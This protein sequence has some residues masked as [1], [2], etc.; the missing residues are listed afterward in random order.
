MKKIWM[1]L[2][3]LLL[4]MIFCVWQSAGKFNQPIA[5]TI[6]QNGKN[7]T[8]KGKFKDITQPERLTKAFAKNGVALSSADKSIDELLVT[9]GSIPLVEKIIPHFVKSYKNGEIK[10]LDEVLSVSGTVESDAAKEEMQKLLSGS[11][12]DINDNTKVVIPVTID[13]TIKQKGNTFVLTGNF[14]N[15][16][17]KDKLQKSFVNAGAK[18]AMPSGHLNPALIDRQGAVSTAS[19]V[20]PAFVSNFQDG[21]IIY[22]DKVLSVN[23][24][25]MTKD[26]ITKV[27][28]QLS[29]AKVQTKNN[30]ILNLEAIKIIED[31]KAKQEAERQAREI[32]EAARVAKMKAEADARRINQELIDAEKKAEMERE[33]EEAKALAAQKAK[34]ADKAAD[35]LRKA[36][37]E[38]KAKQKAIEDARRA[39]ASKMLVDA[40][41]TA[42]ELK[43]MADARVAAHD[44][45]AKLLKLENIEFN[46]AKSTLTAVGKNTVDKLA[47]ILKNYPSVKIE[48]GGHT[49][50]DGK[51]SF[52][53]SLSQAR[54]DTVKAELVSQGISSLRIKAVGYGEIKPLVPNTTDANKQKNRRVEIIILGEK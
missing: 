40:A 4:L 25:V 2:L 53:L 41:P 54:V 14:A 29:G 51:D 45:I 42:A 39:A 28:E 19:K 21:T 12:I 5:Y 32:A 30:T 34:D 36:Q 7:Y 35:A 27:D 50:S 24:K 48:I 10:Y 15:E 23:G 31:A 3:L 44:H 1:P 46:S 52:N 6:S 38:A 47:L 17:Q 20:I 33:A 8:L 9:K 13:F 49:D 18:L 22:Q 43:A 16:A 26:I 11:N 37:E